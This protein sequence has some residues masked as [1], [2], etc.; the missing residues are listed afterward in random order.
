[1]SFATLLVH[2]DVEGALSGRVQLA[3]GL[4]RR[5]Q[6]HLIGA[7]AWMP[8][9]AFVVEGVVVDPEPTED[10]LRKMRETLRSRGDEFR[11]ATDRP[12][13]EWRS[14]LDFPTEYIAREARSADLVVVGREPLPYDP[15][16]S[17]DSGALILRAGRPVLTVPPGIQSLSAERVA[18]AW[19]DARESRRAVADAL[20]FLHEARSVVVIEVCEGGSEQDAQ[21]RL[22]DVADYLAHHRITAVTQRVQPVDGTVAI[23]LLRLV[24]EHSVDLIVAGAYGHSRLG[25]WF[26]GGV[27]QDF[28]TSCPVCCLFSH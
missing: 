14:A 5:F 16:R 18:I 26:F 1:M 11:L 17:P 7:A 12:D 2:V 6:S 4:A 25:E 19:K 23:T 22:R 9:P 21:H 27:T 24:E 28:L 8:R 13:A 15:Y 3:A 10:D 20:P